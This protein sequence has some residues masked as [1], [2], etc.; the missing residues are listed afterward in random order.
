MRRTETVW[1]IAAC[2]FAV[3]LAG[4]HGGHGGQGGDKCAGESLV[5][6]RGFPVL[7]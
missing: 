3:Q 5:L 2:V 6:C 4:G 1:S 7:A